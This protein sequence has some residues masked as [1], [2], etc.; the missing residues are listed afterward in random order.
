MLS[1][2][3]SLRSPCALTG[4]S[5]SSCSLKLLFCSTHIMTHFHSALHVSLATHQRP[6]L[7]SAACSTGQAISED[8]VL[9]G[10]H[11]VPVLSTPYDTPAAQSLLTGYDLAQQDRQKDLGRQETTSAMPGQKTAGREATLSL[12]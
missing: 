8:K 3:G 6:C 2:P 9:F 11:H 5:H 4:C 1:L 10:L 12:H 7:V